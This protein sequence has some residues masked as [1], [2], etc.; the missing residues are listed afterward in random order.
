M[1]GIEIQYWDTCVFLALFKREEHRPGELQYLE[2]QALRF[3][4]GVLGIVTS[5]ITVAEIMQSKQ[6]A[7]QWE[8]WN[9]IY[10]RS[11]F[12][13]VDANYR[14][15]GLASEIRDY[16]FENPVKTDAGVELRL[17]TPDAIHLASAIIA[18]SGARRSIQLLTF[19]DRDKPAKNDIALTRLNG[20][21]AGKYQLH[22]GRP[23]ISRQQSV[24][25]FAGGSAK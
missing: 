7:E 3:D 24:L 25:E 13:F 1:S 12:Q 11:N 16:Y 17:M 6:T 14:V 15:C 21:V 8:R 20:L 5:S 23:A 19:D 4:M 22:V 18:Q 10:S 2:E 9:K